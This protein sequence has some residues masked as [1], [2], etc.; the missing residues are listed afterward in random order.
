MDEGGNLIAVHRMNDTWLASVVIA[1]SKA[2]TPFVLKM[3]TSNLVEA[4]VP[5]G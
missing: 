1:Q 5:H 4:T 2:W 3:T